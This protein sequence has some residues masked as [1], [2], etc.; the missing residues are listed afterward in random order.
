MHALMF[1][2]LAGCYFATAFYPDDAE[3]IIGMR[4]ETVKFQKDFGLCMLS[5]K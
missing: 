1:V 2:V 5:T 3:R 4:T